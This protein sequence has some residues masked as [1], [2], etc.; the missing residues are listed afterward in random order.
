MM[1]FFGLQSKM[2]ELSQEFGEIG[3]NTGIS[4]AK[5]SG[6]ESDQI[7]EPEKKGWSVSLEKRII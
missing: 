4:T 2:R 3:G 6:K 5:V 7:S 1:C